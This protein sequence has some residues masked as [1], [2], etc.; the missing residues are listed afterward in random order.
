MSL[1]S[2]KDKA[3]APKVQRTIRWDELPKHLPDSILC[4]RS[5]RSL[6]EG[7]HGLV[8]DFFIAEILAARQKLG[9]ASQDLVFLNL[10]PRSFG[11]FPLPELLDDN[12]V[13]GLDIDQQAMDSVRPDL[14]P[15]QNEHLALLPVDASLIT[16]EMVNAFRNILEQH[17]R[18]SDDA[19]WQFHNAWQS[20]EINRSLPL[21]DKSIDMAVAVNVLTAFLFEAV[22]ATMSRM[23]W[24]K[25]GKEQS[26]DFMSQKTTF[27]DQEMIYGQLLQ[28]ASNK[29]Y[30][31]LMRYQLTELQRVVKPG[32]GVLVCDHA[33]TLP[34]EENSAEFTVN[35]A[36]EVFPNEQYLLDIGLK[37]EPGK[38]WVTLAV[39]SRA[40]GVK[41]IGRDSLHAITREI[42]GYELLDEFYYWGVNCIG[43]PWFGIP[44]DYCLDT[45]SLL[46]VSA[47]ATS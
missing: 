17:T 1:A 37:F 20:L 23:I 28:M 12:Y 31:R 16:N 21:E 34:R 43:H 46:Q 4:H 27:G 3:L 30:H 36:Y 22:D 9:L 32:G 5:M 19:F 2:V 42:D 8:K 10:G 26:F 39:G 35:C 11:D 7:L 47:A 18:L 44:S 13:I 41:V 24:Q 29:L 25:Y 40:E 38:N 6:T 15:L 14:T 45:G 33:L